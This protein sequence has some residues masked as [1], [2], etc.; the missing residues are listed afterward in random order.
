MIY[1]LRSTFKALKILYLMICAIALYGQPRDYQTGFYN[2][3]S[4]IKLNDGIQ[5]D[6]F[7][8]CWTLEGDNT[9]NYSPWRN[10]DLKSISN[11]DNIIPSLINLYN[12][13]KYEYE[14]QR[15]SFIDLSGTIAINN[16]T[17]LK[18]KNI[19]NTLSQMYSRNKVRNLINDYVYTN[20]IR[21][22][23]VIMTRFDYPHQ[24]NLN[25]KHLDNSNTY[26]S[27]VHRPR[28][29]IA[30]NFIICP[31]YTFLNWMNIY[32][33]IINIVNNTAICDTVKRYGEKLEINPEELL[34]AKYLYDNRNLD[35]IV[36]TTRIKN[37]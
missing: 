2:I 15:T 3:S 10:V 1:I 18:Y 13:T 35:K 37:I 12:P 6:F 21:Y 23:F 28:N 11:N 32:D 27:D 22:D 19:N 9:Y 25:V 24:I 5:F 34:F 20:S 29:I 8:H 14:N 16:I 33:D 7:F 17:G 31:L 4:F 36:Y 26:V 30:D